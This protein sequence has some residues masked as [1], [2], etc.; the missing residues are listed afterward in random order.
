M[1]S[2]DE[3]L[4]KLDDIGTLGVTKIPTRDALSNHVEKG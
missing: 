3:S 1:R 4:S 2:G